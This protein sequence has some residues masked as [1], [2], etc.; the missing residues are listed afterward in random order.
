MVYATRATPA[1]KSDSMSPDWM[2]SPAAPLVGI[3]VDV[4]ALV[5]VTTITD[6]SIAVGLWVGTAQ[7]LA[8][9]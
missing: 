8:L 1:P 5:G 4:F 2:K 6:V 3:G 9:W 7:L